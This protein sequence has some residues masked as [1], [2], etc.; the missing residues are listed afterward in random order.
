MSAPSFP[1][2]RPLGSR[3]LG[4]GT[5]EFRVW[6]PRAE[7]ISLRLGRREHALDDAGYGIYEAV[8]EAQAGDEYWYVVGAADIPTLLARL[9]SPTHADVLEV[10]GTSWRDDR[11]SELEAVI[12]GE[13]PHR[14]SSYS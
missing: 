12:R 8:V 9:G 5:A 13:I 10:L 11:S 14:F 1:W 7:S 2:E 4:D 6:A 3:P